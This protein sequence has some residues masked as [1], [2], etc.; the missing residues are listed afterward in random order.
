MTLTLPPDLE[1]F[2]QDQIARG[3]FP[4]PDGVVEAGL[5]L[6]LDRQA[7]L[8]ALVAAAVGQAD[9]GE[10]TPFDPAATLAEVKAARM[11]RA[12]AP[13]CGG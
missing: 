10:L 7:E 6:L 12:G 5:R 13:P 11:A 1:R 8:K 2:I 3:L 9:R 4:T